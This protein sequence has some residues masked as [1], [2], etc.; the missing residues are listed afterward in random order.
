MK[1][2]AA[3]FWDTWSVIKM[4]CS[5][6]GAFGGSTWAGFNVKIEEQLRAGLTELEIRIWPVGRT[7]ST[8]VDYGM[9]HYFVTLA[10]STRPPDGRHYRAKIEFSRPLRTSV[11]SFISIHQ[12]A[13]NDLDLDLD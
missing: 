9:Y 10:V 4:V 1:V 3:A 11:R 12:V 2:S 13:P 6:F 7:L 8:P 5:S